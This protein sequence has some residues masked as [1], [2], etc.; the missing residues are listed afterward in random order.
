MIS[1]PYSRPAT[2][3]KYAASTYYPSCSGSGAVSSLAS[4]AAGQIV[5]VG[6]AG[7]DGVASQQIDVGPAAAPDDQ[8][9]LPAVGGG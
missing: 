2:S 7:G 1:S 8:A 9:A 3:S 6:V 5:Q 4:D